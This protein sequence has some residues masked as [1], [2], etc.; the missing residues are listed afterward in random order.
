MSRPQ[1]ETQRAI[2]V[3]ILAGLY[4]LRAVP[5][6]PLSV[7]AAENFFLSPESSHT[8]GQWQA[9]PFQ[10]GWMDA[11][12]HDDIAEVSV[13]KAKRVGYTKTLDAFIAYN[14]AHRHRK[15]ALWQPT[16]DDRDS[17]VKSEIDPMLRD[18]DALKAVLRTGKEDTL[19]LKTFLG[20]VL[21][22]L[23]GKAARAYRRITVA[24]APGSTICA[25]I[26]EIFFTSSP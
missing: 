4:P 21:H 9:Y 15:Q 13:R 18:V 19:K 5:P 11:F 17:F 25:R 12:S 20:S 14:A 22:I 10:V 16:D 6:Q 24:V 7:W 26:A 2:L 23:G 1:N 3:A 8:R